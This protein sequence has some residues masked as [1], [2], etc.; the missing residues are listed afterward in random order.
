MDV[1][2][3]PSSYTLHISLPGAKKED[4]GV[5][6]DPEKGVLHIAGVIYRSGD[7]EMM[8]CLQKAERKVGVF[9]RAVK[10]PE[11][12]LTGKDR[13]TQNGGKSNMAEEVDG[14]NIVAKLEDGV[15]VVTVPKILK[16]KEWVDLKRV[17]VE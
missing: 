7:E 8:E 4:F 9:E 11:E 1:F 15:L 16:E 5:N 10:L 3:L 13:S 12:A 14:D 2:N 17:D 6:W